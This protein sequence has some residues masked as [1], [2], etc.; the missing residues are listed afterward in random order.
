MQLSQLVGWFGQLEAG[1]NRIGDRGIPAGAALA[2]S[3]WLVQ[4]DPRLARTGALR[5]RP[6][7]G[8]G[9]AADPSPMRP[10]GDGPRARS[11]NQ[12]RTT[13]ML[14][15]LRHAAAGAPVR[16]EL[17][18]TVRPVGGLPMRVECRARAA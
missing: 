12:L 13:E 6:L 11:D 14:A 5:V 1:T 4:R 17:L 7:L 3:R 2:L 16:S 10:L 15:A 9:A 18:A 8:R